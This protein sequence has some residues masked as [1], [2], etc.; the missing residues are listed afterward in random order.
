M[1]F[2]NLCSKARFLLNLSCLFCNVLPRF[3]QTRILFFFL[4]LVR[5]EFQSTAFFLG[6]QAGFLFCS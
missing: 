2:L 5:L 1:L 4:P 6:S 3:Q